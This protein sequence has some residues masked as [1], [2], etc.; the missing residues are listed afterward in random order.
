[1]SSVLTSVWPALPSHLQGEDTRA[2]K[3]KGLH[4]LQLQQL[5]SDPEI[6][7]MMT[8]FTSEGS[9]SLVVA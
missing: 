6:C 7:E 5:T 4:Q 8:E 9:S 2:T 1:M 3:T